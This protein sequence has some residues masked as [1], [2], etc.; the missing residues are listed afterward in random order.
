[1]HE[2]FVPAILAR[3]K[4]LKPQRILD[5][6]C[7]NGS[8]CRIIKDAG[9]EVEG[10]DPSEE[11]IQQA[12]EAFPD[13]S[14]RRMSIYDQPP[15]EWLNAFDVVVST[16]VIEHLYS[17][18]ALP[19]LAAKLLKPGSVI[20]LTTPY[21]GYWKNLALCLLGKWDHH[22]DPLWDHGHIKF[23]SRQTLTRLFEEQGFEATGFK[24]L[25]RFPLLWMTML[26]EFRQ[27]KLG[28]DR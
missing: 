17:P 9:Y 27:V 1:M 6:G 28:G 7:G 11:G 26:M 12:R 10:A 19:A 18:R 24:G 5:L 20:L 15:K 23:W 4:E 8:L 16:E 3:L 25:G 13:V 21:H 22:H 14:F 2:V